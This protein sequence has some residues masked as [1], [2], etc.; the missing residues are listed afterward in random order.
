MSSI[1]LFNNFIN[2]KTSK[3]KHNENCVNI[4]KCEKSMS[5]KLFKPQAN[6]KNK[7][8]HQVKPVAKPIQ[9][10][11]QPRGNSMNP[12]MTA[13]P[14]QALSSKPD[15]KNLVLQF[16][17]KSPEMRQL[18]SILEMYR[19]HEFKNEKAV[20]EIISESK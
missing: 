14:Q 5:K 16:R 18:D 13:R 15:L 1:S 9:R 3:N 19:A 20:G 17:C 6:S 7:S 4:N 11:R 12:N 2:I 10:T 8:K